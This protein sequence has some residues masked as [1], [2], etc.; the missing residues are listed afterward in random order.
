MLEITNYP[1]YYI[2]EKGDVFSNKRNSLKKLK[3]ENHYTGYLYVNLYNKDGRKHFRVHR[4]V[5]EMFIENPMNKLFVNHIDG[6]KTNNEV[7]NLEWNTSS[8]NTQHAYDNL[9]ANNASGYFDSQSN[10]LIAIRLS[11]NKRFKFGSASIAAK[12]LKISK[13]TIMRQ[14]KGLTNNDY[15]SKFKFIRDMECND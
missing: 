10:N 1:G 9:L 3:L 2:T 6:D 12:E 5:A 14:L 11:D 7:S 13:S 8:E 15:R 4:L